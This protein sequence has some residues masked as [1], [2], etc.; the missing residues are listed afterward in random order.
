MIDDRIVVLGG[1]RTP[2]GSF[3]GALKDVPAH[4]LGALAVREALRRTG[5]DG[6]D[7]DEVVMGCI[8]QV[9]GDAFNARRVAL[10]AGLPV[11]VPAYTVNR[12]C[13]SG[14]QAIWSAAMQIR[15]GSADLALAG[16]DESMSRMPFYDFGPRGSWKLG[17]R[18]L[19]DGTVMM[20]TDPVHGIHMGVTAENVASRYGVSRAEQDDFAV[21]SQQRA[22]SAAA[23]A[24][25]AEEITPVEVR[26]RRAVTVVSEDEHP[27]PG[28]TVEGLA[29]LRPAFQEGGT[30]TAGNSSGINDGAAALVVARE[31]VAR[32]RGLDAPVVLEAVV[33]A[34]MAPELMG[35]A[36]V[37]ALR[38]LFQQTGTSPADIDVVELNE[39]F[40]AQAVAVIR[41]VKLD[42][43]T[44][45]PYGGAIALGHPVGATGAILSLRVVQDLVRRDLELGVVTMCIGG[46]QALA[47]LFRRVA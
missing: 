16:G 10:A 20:L 42:P 3:G 40:A 33:T 17:D 24:A 9:G 19:A 21:R 34:A 4:E 41:D 37:L 27:R 36:P 14:L 35:Y 47:A 29:K 38:K 6:A 31:S 22:G 2:I 43:E 23:R 7:I 12:L 25:F 26:G 11:A 44:V 32:E 46:G 5:V 28:T 8:G 30:V 45:N 15:C 13:G 39:A 1:A 18:S